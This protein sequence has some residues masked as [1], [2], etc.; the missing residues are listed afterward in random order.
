MY[1]WKNNANCK[2]MDTS[3]FFPELGGNI[4]AFVKEVCALCT[5]IEDCLW[6]ANETRSTD[7]VFGGMSSNDREMWRRQNRITLGESRAA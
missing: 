7:G 4:T 6:Y 3:M 1:N 2:N 5:V